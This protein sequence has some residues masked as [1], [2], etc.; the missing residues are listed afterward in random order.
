MKVKSKSK[1]LQ[2]AYENKFAAQKYERSVLFNTYQDVAL[3]AMTAYAEQEK[4]AISDQF[5]SY[6]DENIVRI[7]KTLAGSPIQSRRFEDAMEH[8][9]VYA[10]VKEKFVQLLNNQ[11]K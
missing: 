4:K 5:L 8:R 2:E 9:S 10:S 3:D 1:L 11:I 7:D 6:L